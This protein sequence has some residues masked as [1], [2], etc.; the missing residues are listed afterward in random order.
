MD[1]DTDMDMDMDMDMY[2]I[3]TG[4]LIAGTFIWICTGQLLG[5]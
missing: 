2:W 3:V 4:L 1:M 5:Y